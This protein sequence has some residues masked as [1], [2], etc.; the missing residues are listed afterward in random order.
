M[1]TAAPNPWQQKEGSMVAADDAVQHRV[2]MTTAAPNPLS[3]LH[4]IILNSLFSVLNLICSSNKAVSV[5]FGSLPSQSLLPF[6]S[7]EYT[8]PLWHN[9]IV[10]H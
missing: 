6:F 10:G 7:L 1:T 2:A 5:D 4:N 3:M 8:I 9:K